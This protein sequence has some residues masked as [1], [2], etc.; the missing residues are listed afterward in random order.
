M[1]TKIFLYPERS[2]WENKL[3]KGML[4]G[5]KV[6][7]F[8]SNRDTTFRAIL[9]LNLWALLFPTVLWAG[10]VIMLSAGELAVLL[11]GAASLPSAAQHQASTLYSKL[12]MLHIFVISGNIT[13][14][15]ATLCSTSLRQQYGFTISQLS[16]WAD[17]LTAIRVCTEPIFSFFSMLII[18]FSQVRLVK[19]MGG[20]KK[21]SLFFMLSRVSLF[22]TLKYEQVFLWNFNAGSFAAQCLFSSAWLA[23]QRWRCCFCG[24]FSVVRPKFRGRELKP[25]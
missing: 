14:T 20:G 15:S 21:P 23:L 5:G 3:L 12:F 19:H 24:V 25:S 18:K 10:A 7:F 9:Q 4:R 8:F 6:H 17:N 1:K 11:S 22:I 2:F 16:T 13:F